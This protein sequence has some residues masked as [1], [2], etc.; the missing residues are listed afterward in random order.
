MWDDIRQF[1]AVWHAKRSEILQG[2]F[3]DKGNS[4]HNDYVCDVMTDEK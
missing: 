1:C 4:L 3:R 2:H